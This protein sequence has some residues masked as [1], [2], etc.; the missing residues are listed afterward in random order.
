METHN[1]NSSV[2]ALA[3]KYCKITLPVYSYSTQLSSREVSKA[4]RL[5]S[6]TEEEQHMLTGN[7]FR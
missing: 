5:A 7:K 3:V 2:I 4:W 6:A 1:S